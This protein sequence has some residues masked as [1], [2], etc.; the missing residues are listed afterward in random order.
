VIDSINVKLLELVAR[1]Q[2]A[3]DERGQTTAEYVAVTAVGVALAIA[4]MY[5]L[6]KTAINDAVTD[7]AAAI[8]NFAPFS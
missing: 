3:R 6:M 7:I 1:L 4:V 5:G 8:T 2:G